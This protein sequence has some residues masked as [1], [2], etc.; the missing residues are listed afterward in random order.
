MVL[1]CPDVCTWQTCSIACGQVT[2][3][4]SLAGNA[5]YIAIFCVLL[6]A[7]VILGLKHRT[8]GFLAGMTIGLALEITGY[9]GRIM[10][11]N[12]PF[13]FSAFLL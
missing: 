9:G 4:P 7:H 11:H 12:N 3:V 2:Y 8:W 10:L 13:D 6:V 1:D 5:L